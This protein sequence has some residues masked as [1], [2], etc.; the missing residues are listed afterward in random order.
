MH[1]TSYTPTHRNAF[2]KMLV[3]YFVHDLQ[4]DI[5]EDI[6]RDKLLPHIENQLEKGIIHVA[7]AVE[8][9]PIGFSIYQIDTPESDWCKRPGWGFIR[10]FRIDKTCRGKGYGRK[11]AEHTERKLHALGAAQLYLTSDTAAGFWE[12]CG[13]RN[14]QETCSNGLEIF[15]K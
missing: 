2:E 5:P 8:D 3:E 7:I 14:S 10:E 15:V 12:R 11:L 1:I 9:S 4:S 13:W 6:I